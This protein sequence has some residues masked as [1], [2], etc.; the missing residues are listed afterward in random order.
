MTILLTG[1]DP[2]G[3]EKTNPSWDAVRVLRGRTMR[4]H[5]VVALRLP[6]VFGAAEDALARAL[7]KHQPRVALCVGQAGGRAAISFERVAINLVDARIEDNAGARPVDAPVVAGAPAAYFA[8]APV[9]AMAAAVRDA[10]IPAEVSLTAGSYVCN[11]VFYALMHHVATRMPSLRAGFVHIPFA[12]AQVVAR[13]NVASM[14]RD[15]VVAA[16][17]IASKVALSRRADIAAGEGRLA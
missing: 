1:F 16:L 15:T 12:P 10:G 3:G 2:F 8:S 17:E 9:K 7:E 5:R 11:A 14:P 4:G 13:A 6:T